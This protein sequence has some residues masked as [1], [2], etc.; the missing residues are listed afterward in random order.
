MGRKK[1]SQKRERVRVGSVSLPLWRH[2]KGWRIAWK[3]PATGR[4]SYLTR[5][6]R[7]DAIDAAHAKALALQRGRN[8]VADRLA[9]DPETAALIARVLAMGLTHADLDRLAETRA[10][11][12]V[13]LSDAIGQFLAAKRAARGPSARNL[14]TL[15]SAL[16]GLLAHFP[17]D[18]P[19][20]AITPA[21]LERWMSAGAVAARTVRNRRAVAV[22]FFRWC[23]S[24]RLLPDET[25]AAERTERPIVRRIVPAT[26]TPAEL[27]TLWQVCPETHRA[28]L[29]LSAWAGIRGEELYQEIEESRKDVLR[30]SDIDD[31]AGH[32]LI[33]PLVA[34]TGDRRLI[35]ITPALRAFLASERQAHLDR[36]AA[37]DPVC[38]GRPPSRKLA[39]INRPVTAIL[40]DAV[41]GWR[42]N[43]L[44]H[45]FISYRAALV[46]LARAALEAGNSESEARK[47]YH[48]AMPEPLAKE[49]FN[50]F[51]TSSEP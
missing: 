34:K 43:A 45:S 13:P 49:W 37:N 20:S 4:W 14:R 51:G 7:E 19:L 16:D 36:A 39:G 9:T 23:R 28:W 35:P 22:T 50:P 32:I 6:R 21:D 40:G 48:D 42:P 46:G 24:R 12:A 38:R 44:R 15:E 31:T 11:P 10:A 33:R 26:W 25:T 30:W 18:P 3:D 5:S 27:R 2:A 8:A 17:A 1:I 41:G 47:S 29:A